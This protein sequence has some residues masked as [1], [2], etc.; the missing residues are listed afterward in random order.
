MQDIALI[1]AA[2]YDILSTHRGYLLNAPHTVNR[3]FKVRH[4]DERM[5]E[6]LCS[7]VDL[8]GYV[9]NVMVIRNRKTSPLKNITSD[10]HYHTVEADSEKTLDMIEDMLREKGF[11]VEG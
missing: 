1:R 9:V 11:L 2:G 8:G 10:Y 7:I 6:E 5:E 3:T 4:T